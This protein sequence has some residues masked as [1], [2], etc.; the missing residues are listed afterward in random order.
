MTEK[1]S[2]MKYSLEDVSVE[3]AKLLDDPAHDQDTIIAVIE[4]V[5]GMTERNKPDYLG[6]VAA[7]IDQDTPG[8]R[9]GFMSSRAIMGHGIPK[10]AMGEITR[11][12]GYQHH[13]VLRTYNGAAR[14]KIGSYTLYV[15][16]NHYTLDNP[17]AD[18]MPNLRKH[19]EFAQ[20][21]GFS[22]DTAAEIDKHVRKETPPRI[23]DNNPGGVKMDSNNMKLAFV[24]QALVNNYWT[25][26]RGRL[27]LK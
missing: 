10:S 11:V 22:M 14:D 1:V 23:L 20:E 24:D 26:A 5:A 15:K 16:V 25:K 13:P 3:I 17:I 6:K 8:F 21:W 4:W 9:C 27:G 18:T 19:Y 7:L 12:L 2:P